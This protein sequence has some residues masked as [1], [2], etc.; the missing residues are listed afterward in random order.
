MVYFSRHQQVPLQGHP[1]RQSVLFDQDDL[2]PCRRALAG[3]ID[4]FQLSPEAFAGPTYDILVQHPAHRREGH[5]C[6]GATGVWGFD[7]LKE[8][9]QILQRLHCGPVCRG[10]I[11]AHGCWCTL[12]PRSS[13]GD[14]RPA[15]KEVEL[16]YNHAKRTTLNAK[17][18]LPA[19]SLCQAGGA[20]CAGLHPHLSSGRSC[21]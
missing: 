12:E 3:C 4:E 1:R 19:I 9:P 7:N 10:K 2:D 6:N 13:K 16:L 8:R 11:A 5:A 20:C 17:E 15:L 14:C 21:V 18:C